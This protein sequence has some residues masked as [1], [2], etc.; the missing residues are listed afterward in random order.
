MERNA[1]SAEDRNKT[2]ESWLSLDCHWNQI[3]LFC[4]LV[5]CYI[6][7]GA[8]LTV[9]QQFFPVFN[10][11]PRS[12]RVIALTWFLY[13]K[14]SNPHFN[15]SNFFKIWIFAVIYSMW[16]M[17]RPSAVKCK[18]LAAQ[19]RQAV[20]CCL[21]FKREVISCGVFQY[22]GVHITTHVASCAPII[23]ELV[24]AGRINLRSEANR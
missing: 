13:V 24:P 3:C 21:K 5:P 23:R 7:T 22:W 20:F 4:N 19:T 16:S 18:L 12:V 1:S 2:E 9:L 8:S 15:V 11:R 10:I 6:T 14:T 17:S